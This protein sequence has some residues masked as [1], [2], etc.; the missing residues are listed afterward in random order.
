[1][2]AA[3]RLKLGP[4]H[5]G[6]KKDER[7]SDRNHSDD[8][9]YGHCQTPSFEE[10]DYDQI[11]AGRFDLSQTPQSGAVPVAPPQIRPGNSVKVTRSAPHAIGHGARQP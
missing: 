3:A 9:F 11:T 6:R 2:A 10:A 4:K 7:D 5:Y 1:M 8:G